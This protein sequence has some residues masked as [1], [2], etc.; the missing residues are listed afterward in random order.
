MIKEKQEDIISVQDLYMSKVYVWI[1][2]LI[3]GSIVAA[4]VTFTLLKS[5]GFYSSI[6]W[7]GLIVFDITD[8]LYVA[9]GIY[10]IKIAFEGEKL[11]AGMLNKGKSYLGIIMIIQF[12]FMIYLIPTREFW[13]MTFFFLIL[14]AF[15]L[16]VKF[17]GITSGMIVVS[18][19][20][21]AIIR[22]DRALPVQDEQF[23]TEMIIRII[24]FTLSIGS[25]NL[26][27][28][29]VGSFLANAKRDDLEQKQNKAQNVLDKV[30]VVGEV[31][32]ETS[33]HVL[34]SAQTQSSSSQELSAIT[35]E[36]FQMSKELLQDFS[37]NTEK[38]S[39]LND[40]SE[41]V[42]VTIDKV[43]DMSR[44]LVELSKNNEDSMNQLMEGSEVVAKA[45]Q[46]VID[47][48]E[49][50][51]EGTRQVVTTLDIINQI[52]SSTNLLAL[53]ASIEAARA[54]DVGRGFGVVAS[55]IGS[56]AV[57]TQESLREIHKCMDIL[58]E[59]TELVSQSISTSS[60]KLTEQNTVMGET[61]KKVNSM[62]ELLNNCLS[63]M[64]NVTLENKKQKELVEI[65]FA[66]NQ[67]M[68][69]QIKMQ[70]ERFS[71]IS[72]VVQSNTEEITDLT[73]QV[74][75]LDG[76]VRELTGL[77]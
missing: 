60:A 3:T 67:K 53:N 33:S 15:F 4:G 31:L 24:V 18:Y 19:V 66:C 20:I 32:K 21:F 77:L 47:A 29:F 65:S 49:S 30:S 52:A 68:Q 25:I 10:L 22:Y 1:M 34:Q 28:W 69:D 62:M 17:T 48:V 70:D 37:K 39:Q 41:E 71:Q 38:L 11:K 35:E 44:E 14:T 75:Q 54:G 58:V 8:L 76:I 36:L 7:I 61:V 16:D 55:E 13:A 40:T 5:L 2:L 42:S 26:I 63:S 6:P 46:N 43:S 27:T 50:L 45:N 51:L 74:G 57:N 59:N 12:N 73:T 64:E 72:D 9:A 23:V 56:L